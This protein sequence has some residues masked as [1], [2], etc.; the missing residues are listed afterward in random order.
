MSGDLRIIPDRGGTIGAIIDALHEF[1]DHF[2]DVPY[3]LIGGLAVLAHVPGHRVTQDI[4]SA[5]RG[6]EADVRARLLEVATLPPVGQATAVLS[7]GV[8][9]DIAYASPRPPR[10]GLG[11]PREARLR[12]RNWAIETAVPLTLVSAPE[13]SRGPVTVPT[14]IPAALVAMKVAAIEAPD[15]G[16][17]RATDILDLW[18]LL[19]DDPV[20][21]THL[22]DDLA[23]APTALRTWVADRLHHHMHEGLR[24]FV[25]DMASGPGAATSPDD[26]T[27]LRDALITPALTAMTER[28]TP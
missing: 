16:D 7:G 17:K 23:V 8:P 18:R 13:S 12:A 6:F 25:A 1:V 28:G 2:A 11:Q 3:A 15:R 10:P 9:I 5:V 21:T 24:A 19:S 26:V 14:A 20:A 22:L 27:D 4:D